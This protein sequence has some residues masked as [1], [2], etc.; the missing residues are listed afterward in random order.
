MAKMRPFMQ[1][2]S[3]RNFTREVSAAAIALYAALGHVAQ[4]A[5]TAIPPKT[6]VGPYSHACRAPLIP[7]GELAGRPPLFDD[8][9]ALTYPVTT[10]SAEAQNYFDQGLRLSYAFNHAEARR[11]F[12]EA[13]RLDPTCAMC[14]WGE[15]LVLGPNINAPMEASANEPALAALAK[16]KIATTGAKEKEQGLVAALSARYSD[17]PGAERA[18]L[19]TAYAD[20]MGK[21]VEKYPQDLEIA[22]LYAEAL[23]DL[24]PWDYWEAGGARPKGRTAEIVATLERVLAGYPD[25]PG[26]IHLYI[27]T[28]EAS[29]NPQR[30]ER[31]AVRLGAL[32]PG[33]GHIVHMP[34]H[35]YYRIGRYQDALA[36]NKAAVAADERYI[37]RVKGQSLYTAMYYPHNVHFL[38]AAAQMSG[39][40]QAA[41]AAADKLAKLVP[42]EAA[43]TIPLA[44][45]IKAAP[46][47]AHVL[48]GTTDTTLALAKPDGIPYVE[49]MWHYARGIAYVRQGDLAA[50]EA[51]AGS[52]GHL[53]RTSDFAA[54]EAVAIPSVPVLDLAREVLLG[55]IVQRKGDL[56]AAIGH[57]QR[58]TELQDGL[59][60]MEPPYWYYPVR[61]SL[62]ALLLQ[63]GRATDAEAAFRA[64]LKQTPSNGWALFGLAETLRARGDREAAAEV[65]ARLGKAWAGDP[66]QLDLGRL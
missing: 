37:D 57:F 48:F 8:L 43:R 11:A 20:A 17:A 18:I 64:V 16:A 21:L 28:V 38:M 44:Q 63:A 29:T 15:A 4:A 66:A 14:F 49:A 27:H 25:H 41:L 42:D 6:E 1:A 26:A 51:E 52:I 61:Q 30:A 19:D 34:S 10:T 35:I 12:Q 32:M 13:Q 2:S 5:E 24:S 39:D 55:R 22:V 54:L 46:Y 60:Y 62:G 23:M 36:S 45:P 53:A 59:P 31:H 9:G 40:G 58:A 50:A 33:A 56:G 3:C 65:E 47:F 7:A